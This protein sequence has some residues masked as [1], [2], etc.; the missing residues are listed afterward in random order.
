VALL[1][2]ASF[3][4]HSETLLK[5]TI[6]TINPIHGKLK[7]GDCCEFQARLGYRV[8]QQQPKRDLVKRATMCIT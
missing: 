6:T 4:W 3:G 7:Q 1:S 5:A 8:R 2:K